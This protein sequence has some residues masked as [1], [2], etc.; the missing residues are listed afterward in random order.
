MKKIK[1][2]IPLAVAVVFFA[3]LNVQA[4][5]DPSVGRWASRDP[6]GEDGSEN[7]YSIVDNDPVQSV[8]YLGECLCECVTRVH[9]TNIRKYR[10]G[11]LFGHK[12][13]I[14]ISLQTEPSKDGG[15]YF[16]SLDWSEKV[17][18]TPGWQ[19]GIPGY[20]PGSGIIC[21]R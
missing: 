6:V 19:N 21:S 18:P 16:A 20:N 12:F 17:S 5:F 9:L 11:S 3:A 15:D 7:L 8:D 10:N 4:Y 2:V 13:D 14:V 1:N